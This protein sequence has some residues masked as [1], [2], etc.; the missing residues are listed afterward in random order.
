MFL[1]PLQF[2]GLGLVVLHHLGYFHH[3]TPKIYIA[4]VQLFSV[5]LISKGLGEKF[6]DPLLLALPNARQVELEPFPD[7]FSGVGKLQIFQT[8][9]EKAGVEINFC[10]QDDGLNKIFDFEVNF[11]VLWV[12]NK[13]VA[14]EVEDKIVTELNIDYARAKDEFFELLLIFRSEAYPVV[15][16][17]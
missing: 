14:E 15:S 13:V 2:I 1:Y 17:G 5:L 4:G 11:E 3:I 10:Q 6:F 7:G 16:I 12:F 9:D 8:F